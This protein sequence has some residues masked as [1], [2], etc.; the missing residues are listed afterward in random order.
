MAE[1]KKKLP[2][3]KPVKLDEEVHATLTIQAAQAGLKFNEYI[4]LCLAQC[5]ASKKS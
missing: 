2:L 5:K 4:K 1:K 3:T